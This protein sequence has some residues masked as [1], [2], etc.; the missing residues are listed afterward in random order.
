M[1]TVELLAQLYLTLRFLLP[2][3]TVHKSGCGLML[4]LKK[5]MAHAAIGS[6]ITLVGNVAVKSSLALFNGENITVCYVTCKL[7]GEMH[8]RLKTRPVANQDIS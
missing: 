5:V 3:L 4:P 7:E 8:R 1:L 2:L 6:A